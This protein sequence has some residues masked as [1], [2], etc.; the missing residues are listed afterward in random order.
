MKLE[1]RFAPQARAARWDL[2]LTFRRF[3]PFYKHSFP[4]DT[5]SKSGTFC[6]RTD[7][8]TDAQIFQDFGVLG[9]H[10]GRLKTCPT[11]DEALILESF[12]KH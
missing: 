3:A 4:S 10:S 9:T 1:C 11:F 5:C 6:G 8:R 2:F 7:G 12:Q